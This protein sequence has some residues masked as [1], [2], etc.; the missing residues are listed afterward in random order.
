MLRLYLPTG[1][2]IIDHRAAFIPVPTLTCLESEDD[3]RRLLVI[4]LGNP[5]SLHALRRFWANWHSE[6]KRVVQIKDRVLIDRIARM[7]IDGPL[8]AFVVYDRDALHSGTVV[9]KAALRRA[10]SAPAPLPPVRSGPGTAT[11]TTRPGIGPPPMAD[12]ARTAPDGTGSETTSVAINALSL[13]QRLERVLRRTPPYLPGAMRADFMKLLAP[14]ALLMT[15]GVLAVWAASHAVGVGFIIDALLLVTGVIFMGWAVIDAARK[16]HK[17][18]EVTLAAREDRDLEQAAKLLAEVVA[19]I[20]VAA[21]VAAITHGASRTISSAMKG[22]GPARI[23][24]EPPRRPPERFQP[25]PPAT[26]HVQPKSSATMSPSGKKIGYHATHPDAVAAIQKG[27][28]R[29][30]TKPGRLG[31]GGV[32]VNDTVDGAIAEFSFH[33]PGVKPAILEVE[34]DAGV[35][36]SASVPPRLYVKEHPLDLDSITAPSLRAPG[37]QNTNILNGSAK[38][39]KVV[40]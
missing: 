1:N 4:A 32:Y 38:P 8:A 6:S 17:A 37:T 22:K 11:A 12:A 30:G 33:N 18:L 9:R 39:T 21:F 5:T 35:N 16:L 10:A 28:F 26:P 19:A 36:A 2:L 24:R 13:E 15:V 40:Q 7:A 20:G 31:S 23:P 27:G 34:Y 14:D 25:R 29:P 3:V